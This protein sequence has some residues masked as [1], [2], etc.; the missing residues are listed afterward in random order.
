MT[1]ICT[2]ISGSDWY[3]HHALGTVTLR[4]Y[5]I[6]PITRALAY[7]LPELYAGEPP[8]YAT[9]LY[10]LIKMVVHDPVR[11]P[12]QIPY[13]LRDFLERLLVKN[14]QHRFSW[15]NL[16]DH[17]YVKDCVRG[18]SYWWWLCSMQSCG[19]T[20]N[21]LYANCFSF[22]SATCVSQ[23]TRCYDSYAVS[24]SSVVVTLKFTLY[25]L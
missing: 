19:I 9:G 8:F 24:F 6:L 17:P 14:P 15:P 2:I 16:L 21:S 23:L 12:S 22:F 1:N 5:L 18:S 25:T 4:L 13:E 3:I 20:N 11:W 7:I 10:W